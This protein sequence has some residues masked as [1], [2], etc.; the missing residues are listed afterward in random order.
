MKYVLIWMLSL[1]VAIG[2]ADES[3]VELAKENP[4]TAFVFAPYLAAIEIVERVD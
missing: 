4:V 1:G 3:G 2:L